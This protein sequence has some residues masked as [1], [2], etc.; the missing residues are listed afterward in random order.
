MATATM[1]YIRLF[2]HSQDRDAVLEALQQIEAV[3]VEHFELDEKE[4]PG[5]KV[6][7]PS[8]LKKREEAATLKLL[9]LEKT[10]RFLDRYSSSRPFVEKLREPLPEVDLH[11][12]E[13]LRKETDLDKVLEEAN[14]LE[15]QLERKAREAKSLQQSIHDLEH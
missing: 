15:K 14:T 1:K 3:H 8:D 9:H 12:V 13:S 5:L 10:L 4:E 11:Q 6:T 7:P 2:G